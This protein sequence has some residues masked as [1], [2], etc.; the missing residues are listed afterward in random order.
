M[1]LRSFYFTSSP[2]DFCITH[3]LVD[4]REGTHGLL[5]HLFA[6]AEH[7]VLLEE[8]I[9]QFCYTQAGVDL[10]LKPK[11]IKQTTHADFFLPSSAFL[12]QRPL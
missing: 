6:H 3:G 5:H 8:L 4:A 10:L 7:V 9:R 1:L 2:H 11:R 12:T